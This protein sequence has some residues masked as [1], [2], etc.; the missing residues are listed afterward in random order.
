MTEKSDTESLEG[1]SS[2]GQKAKFKDYFKDHIKRSYTQED[3]ESAI[4]AVQQGHGVCDASRRNGIPVSTLRDHLHSRG[5]DYPRLNRDEYKSKYDEA[6]L[7]EAF[8]AVRNGSSL[9]VSS[10]LSCLISTD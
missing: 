3:L 9:M 6:D 5:V 2:S 10:E 4:S 7:E 1:S 8:E